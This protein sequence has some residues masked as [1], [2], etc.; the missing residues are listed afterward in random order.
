MWIYLVRHAETDGNRQRIVQQP[1]TPLS[2]NGLQQAQALASAYCQLPIS[3]IV[4]SDYARARATAMPLHQILNCSFE[5]NPMLRERNFGDL[6]GQA[7]DDI[8]YDFFAPDYHPP[9]GESHDQFVSRVRTAW[10]DI[11]ESTTLHDG[12]IMVM[13]HGLVVHCILQDILMLSA[14]ALAK[15]KI[16][17]TCVSKICQEQP[18]YVPLLC[19]VSHLQSALIKTGEQGKV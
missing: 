19:D 14:E 18:S 8:K 15:I 9:N 10:Q 17:N 3:R 11:I 12:D 16:K 2:N 5:P 1:D 6:R 13:T 7:Y 4:C